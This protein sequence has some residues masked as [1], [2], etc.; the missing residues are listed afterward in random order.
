MEYKPYK[1]NADVCR[2]AAR[3]W[4]EHMEHPRYDQLG[5]HRSRYSV[6]ERIGEAIGQ[7]VVNDLTRNTTSQQL[8]KFE[9]VLVDMLMS[10]HPLDLVPD[11]M[12]GTHE[13]GY[14]K[15]KKVL[16]DR[17]GFTNSGHPASLFTDYYPDYILKYAAK[18]TGLREEQVP[19]KSDMHLYEN[20]LQCRFGCGGPNIHYYLVDGG[21]FVTSLYGS[22]E[23]IAL[24][25]Q[26]AKE[27][28]AAG[29]KPSFTFE[30]GLGSLPASAVGAGNPTG[31]GP[32]GREDKP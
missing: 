14:G 15:D 26:A 10:E 23:D 21:W 24:V 8:D 20:F 30:K 31:P 12:I 9:A 32:A 25:I 7:S 1:P 5:P 19:I 11:E 22:E 13:E 6:N 3:L 18:M 4:R 28:N 2:K 17:D 16:S 29:R 27:W